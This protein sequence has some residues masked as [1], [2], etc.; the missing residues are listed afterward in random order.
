[1]LIIPFYTPSSKIMDWYW[2]DW[3]EDLI[4]LSY[5]TPLSTVSRNGQFDKQMKVR[6]CW[7]NSHSHPHIFSKLHFSKKKLT[8]WIISSNKGNV[9][10]LHTL[11]NSPLIASIEWPQPHIKWMHSNDFDQIYPLWGNSN[12]IRNKFAWPTFLPQ[13]FS[14]QSSLEELVGKAPDGW[15]NAHCGAFYFSA[16]QFLIQVSG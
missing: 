6:W 14:V 11:F 5:L 12:H 10:H 1:M 13:P 7:N 15:L 3:P 16:I 4:V 8:N 9:I 2:V